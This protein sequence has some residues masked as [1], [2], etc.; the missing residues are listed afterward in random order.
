MEAGWLSVGKIANSALVVLGS[1]NHLIELYAVDS[2]IEL[3]KKNPHPYEEEKLTPAQ[4]TGRVAESILQY[5]MAGSSSI[6]RRVEEGHMLLVSVYYF[7]T[8]LWKDKITKFV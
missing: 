5:I 4:I 8:F 7:G 3:D 1:L 6:E 2:K